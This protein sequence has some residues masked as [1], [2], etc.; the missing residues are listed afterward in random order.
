MAWAIEL[1]ILVYRALMHTK[2]LKEIISLV[3]RVCDRESLGVCVLFFFLFDFIIIYCSEQYVWIL[4][5]CIP[6]INGMITLYVCVCLI[7]IIIVGTPTANESSRNR[8]VGKFEKGS[9]CYACWCMKSKIRLNMKHKGRTSRR[10]TT[11]NKLSIEES[12][13]M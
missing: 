10:K 1:F 5:V 9:V 7:I 2:N 13:V 12:L 11:I 3:I 4:Y 6:K 8:L